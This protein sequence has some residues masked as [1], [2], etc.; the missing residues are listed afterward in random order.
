MIGK[1]LLVLELLVRA[2]VPPFYSLPLFERICERKLKRTPDDPAVLWLLGNLYLWHRRYDKVIKP[3]KRLVD[4]GRES[5]EVRLSLAR[6]YF[7]MKRHRDVEEVLTKPGVL[8][9]KDQENYYLGDS[10]VNLGKYENAI[11]YLVNYVRYHTKESLPLVRLGYAYY[12]AGMF[13]LALD[14][15]QRAGTL[16]PAN[17]EIQRSIELCRELSTQRV[18]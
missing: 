7:Q 2:V 11:E 4:L 14:A 3:L 16:D 1:S 9:K 8:T 15:Y 5:R 10:L 6:A 17:A 12:K 13:D 18:Q